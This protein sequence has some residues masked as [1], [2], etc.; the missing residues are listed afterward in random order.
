[1]N[2]PK[3]SDSMVK[4]RATTYGDEYFYCRNCK[5]ELSEMVTITLLSEQRKKSVFDYLVQKKRCAPG[6]TINH[7][8]FTSQC[9]AN[10]YTL[11]DWLPP[12]D[13]II[14]TNPVIAGIDRSLDRKRL[15]GLRQIA[16]LHQSIEEV[17]VDGLAYVNRE[18]S[19]PDLCLLPTHKYSEL[20][21][22]LGYRVNKVQ[23]IHD[24]DATIKFDGLSFSGQYGRITVLPCPILDNSGYILDFSSFTEY[25]DGCLT[26]LMCSRPGH[27]LHVL[28]GILTP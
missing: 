2:C 20:F 27:N 1:M 22:S 23:V 12:T 24:E 15:G 16:S 10:P 13:C 9:K 28:F 19:K 25:C 3:C 8:G 4:A 21:N 17:L 6:T 14:D 18:G 11:N 5:K 26:Q 7:A